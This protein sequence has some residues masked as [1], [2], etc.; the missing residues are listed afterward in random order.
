MK[1]SNKK[2]I[3]NTVQV[4]RHGRNLFDLSHSHTTSFNM[5]ELIPISAV[6][7]VPGDYMTV[8]HAGSARLAPMLAPIYHRVNMYQHTWFVPLRL[9]WDNFEEWISDPDGS[10][11]TCPYL[12]V[13]NV[14]PDDI[15][16]RLFNYLG[17][18]DPSQGDGQVEQINAWA[19]AAYQFIYQEWYRD[20]NLIPDVD[21]KL[22]D[23]SNNLNGDLFQL[24]KR[25]WGH[26]YLTSCLPFAQK[27][28]AVD[29][30]LGGFEDVP[31]F[32]K[33]GVGISDTTLTGAPQNQN[34]DTGTP[35][36]TPGI[37]DGDMFAQTSDIV[38]GT[39][40]INDLRTAT[41]VQRIKELFARVG[42][43]YREFVK[44]I[45]DTD[46]EDYRAQVPEYVTGSI[47]PISISE[48]L[49]TTG[50]D[51]LPQGNMSGHGVTYLKGGGKGY[52]CKDYGILITIANVQ[53]ITAYQNGISRHYKKFDCLDY[54]NPQMDGLGE[55]S[56]LNSEVFAFHATG[57]GTFG[58][59]PYG[60]EYRYQ[61]NLTTGDFQTSLNYWTMTR[62]FT[63]PV[64][65]NEEFITCDPTHRIFAVTDPA[66]QK[67][68]A[69]FI[70]G[71][72]A[73]RQMS[74]YGTPR[75]W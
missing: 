18:P 2:N 14:A 7:C 52:K 33:A 21:Y 75:L 6:P 32:R 28:L 61:N 44:G 57:S 37:A 65:L 66:V 12:N 39:T 15:Y 40:S 73:Q 67:I 26:D 20:Q 53:P 59:I 47:S 56:V 30:P 43:R 62:E 11:F 54:W 10:S 36:G 68:Y 70:V 38:G 72:H 63:N 3:F 45:F 16:T 50:T 27:G 58:Y 5:G 9:L 22:V 8:H 74:K 46:I 60:A 1:S 25:A 49:N 48:V 31:V 35:N 71:I 19:H 34:L 42:S 55:Q 29:M 24:R 64:G 23:G 17:I 4:Q 41:M 51:D 13:G 69:Q